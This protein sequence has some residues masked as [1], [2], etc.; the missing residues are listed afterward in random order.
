M[1][2]WN[3]QYRIAHKN[4]RCEYCRAPIHIGDRY[5]RETGVVS[6]EF[7]DYC[8]CERCR[9]VCTDLNDGWDDTLGDFVC[10]ISDNDIILC[11]SCGSPNMREIDYADD[12]M[13]A[14]CE[15]DNCDCVFTADLSVAG[16]RRVLDARSNSRFRNR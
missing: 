10:D 8:L 6:S 5:S 14:K 13:S 12:M 1:S 15:C 2:F 3:S 7:N 9:Q 4:Y 11:P 16:I